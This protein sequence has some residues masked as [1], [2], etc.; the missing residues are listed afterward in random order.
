MKTKNYIIDCAPQVPLIKIFLCLHII[1]LQTSQKEYFVA[2]NLLSSPQDS[3]QVGELSDCTNAI[4]S[5]LYMETHG[6]KVAKVAFVVI[7]DAQSCTAN[8]QTQK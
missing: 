4:H 3:S 6:H 1:A 2:L 8:P 7:P 5:L